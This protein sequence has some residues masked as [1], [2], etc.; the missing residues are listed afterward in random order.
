[1]GEETDGELDQ[2]TEPADVGS[3][4]PLADGPEEIND[5][6]GPDGDLTEEPEVDPGPWRSLLYPDDWTPETTDDEGR[7]LHDFSYAGY[8]YGETPLA[9]HVSETVFD[10]VTDFGADPTGETDS[11]A[12]VQAAIDEAELAGGVVHFPVGLYRFDGRLGI[13]A[14]NVVLRGEGPETSRLYFTSSV[15]MAYLGHV[16]FAGALTHDLEL[17]LVTDAGP[18]DFTVEVEDAGDLAVGDDVAIGWV[19]TPEFVEE[20]VMTGSWQAF[21]DTWQPFFRREVVNIDRT[22]SPHRVTL[23]VPLRY[24]AKIRD[25]ASLRREH[26][27]LS[28]C[29]FESLG[30]ANA[31]A[32][33]DAWAVRQVHVVEM[34]GVEDCWI[35][36]IASFPSPIAPTEGNGAGMHL[37]GGGIVVRSSKRVTVA[38]S[39]LELAQNRGSGGCGY[40]FEVRTS[41]EVLFSDLLGRAGRHN[42]IQNWGFGV[43]GCVWLRVHSADGRTVHGSAGTLSSV[44]YSEFHHS[45]ATANLIDSSV[46]DDGWSAVNRKDESSG[47]GHTATDNVI[48]NA[49]GEGLVRSYQYGWGYVI[50]TGPEITVETERTPAPYGLEEL[51]E[52]LAAGTD[53]EPMDWAE[54]VG[55]AEMLEPSS[56]YEDQLMRRLGR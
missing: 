26:G 35:R 48:W 14:S 47:A 31:V 6:L 23:D 34:N 24:P 1:M 7:F 52:L 20:H 11:T 3:D 16:T 17:P 41:S 19:I 15:D 43:S 46:L 36:D 33:D 54:G 42:F 4:S 53:T 56:L 32:W 30:V 50:G 22:A 8:H 25:G 40:L 45:L 44:G 12:V 13:N 28:E 55:R 51:W 38:D 37:Q 21:N 5:T 10:V 49:S 9:Q 29:G 18:R 2:H 39:S 27:Y